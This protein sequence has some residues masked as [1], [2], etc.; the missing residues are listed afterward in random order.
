[1]VNRLSPRTSVQAEVGAAKT[2]LERTAE[3]FDLT[4]SRSVADGGYGSAEMVGWLEYP[5]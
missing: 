1:M 2:M 5:Y 4:P 3:Q